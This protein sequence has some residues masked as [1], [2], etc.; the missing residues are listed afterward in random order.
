MLN[1]TEIK[2]WTS[3]NF[4][5][6]AE[7]M[8]LFNLGPGHLNWEYAIN[9]QKN[10]KQDRENTIL[11]WKIYICVCLHFLARSTVVII[12]A[13]AIIYSWQFC[14]SQLHPRNT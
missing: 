12:I 4:T 7:T 14:F 10:G 5:E 9:L 2:Q 6:E 3:A 8:I 11:L 1:I 13:L